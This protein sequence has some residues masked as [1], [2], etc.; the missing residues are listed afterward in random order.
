M[1]AFMSLLHSFF[2]EIPLRLHFICRRFGTLSLCSIYEDVSFCYEQHV[3]EN[4]Y[5]AVG[6]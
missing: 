1:H 3:D 6:G 4:Q 2:W 5:G